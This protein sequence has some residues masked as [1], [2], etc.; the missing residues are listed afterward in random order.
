MTVSTASNLN[1][2]GQLLCIQN[3]SSFLSVIIAFEIIFPSSVLVFP[4]SFSMQP[5]YFTSV[6]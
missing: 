3:R 1:L 5:R 2:I 6:F 4:F